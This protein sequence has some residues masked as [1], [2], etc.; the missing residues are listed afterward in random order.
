MSKDI[1]YTTSF[2]VKKKKKII[3]DFKVLKFNMRENIV[4]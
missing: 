1:V 3:F 2:C 4:I